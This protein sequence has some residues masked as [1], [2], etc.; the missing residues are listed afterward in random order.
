MS[1][2]NFIVV[3]LNIFVI[4]S[5]CNDVSVQRHTFSMHFCLLSDASNNPHHL[6]I[7]VYQIPL[8]FTP[9]IVKHGNSKR[10]LPFFPTWPSTKEMIKCESSCGPKETMSRVC[11]RA[12]GIQAAAAPGQLPRNERQVKYLKHAAKSFSYTPADELY[13]VM[14]QAK[15][16]DQNNTFVRD[17]KVLPDPAILIAKD[18]QLDDL[19]RFSTNSTEHCILTIDPTFSLGDFDV[20]PI[21]YRHL[22]LETK[23][24][25]GPILVHYKKAFLTYL[26]KASSLVGLQKS[27][28]HGMLAFGTDGEE[29][30]TQAFKHEFH[31]ARVL[32]TN[33][34]TLRKS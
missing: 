29:A 31:F 25:V 12:G 6:G 10:D 27:G 30:L 4:P 18:Y 1:A 22:L 9:Q 20:T 26:S 3:V 21:T 2:A 28:W 13:S 34:E 32:S 24:P 15:Q 5:P 17:I 11:S 33:V 7:L 8:N 16:E 19:V 23:T 14:F